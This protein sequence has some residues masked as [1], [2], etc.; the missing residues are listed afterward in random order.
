MAASKI[1]GEIKLTPT[2]FG[3]LQGLKGDF[4]CFNFRFVQP[5]LCKGEGEPHN[6]ETNPKYIVRLAAEN[7]DIVVDERKFKR[8]Y[9]RADEMGVNLGNADAASL[10]VQSTISVQTGHNRGD[11]RLTLDSLS[12]QIKQ[13]ISRIQASSGSVQE[14]FAIF[15]KDL[16]GSIDK[17][18][19]KVGLHGLGVKVS[20]AELDLVWPMF[21]TGD[22]I[23]IVAFI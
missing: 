9:M 20:A 17:N 16:S 8:I 14:A 23:K 18:E 19:F 15:D 4:S 7:I 22:A 13:A 21:D 12:V 5:K 11:V 2:N 1:G 3:R 10:E 6:T